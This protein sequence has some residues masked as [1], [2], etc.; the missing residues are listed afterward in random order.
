MDLD[1]LRVI[2][3]RDRE[4]A[5][6]VIAESANQ[7]GFGVT[8]QDEPDG[9][10]EIDNIVLSGMG[11]SCLA[12]LMAKSWLDH[13]YQLSIPFEITRGYKLPSYVN[14]KTL[15]ICLSVSGNTEETLSSFDDAI[16]RGAKVVA[17][18]SGGKLLDLAREKKIPFTQL[19]KISQPRYGIFMHLRV[20]ARILE[21][22][23]LIQGAYRE[24]E[25]AAPVVKRYADKLTSAIP[26]SRNQAKLLATACAG[27]TPLVYASSLFYPLAYK[28]KTSFNENAKNTI[29]C[30]EFSEF[31]HNEFI[32]WT[33]HPID[34][35]F[36]IINLR[37]NIDSDRMNQRFD[38]TDQLL[39]GHRPAAHNISLYGNSVLEQMICGAILGDFASIYL[40]IINGVDPTPVPLVEKFKH[41]LDS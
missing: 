33:S 4:N 18:S 34:K 7:L 24:I 21:S 17:V 20:I 36:A 10:G 16:N 41:L 35:P 30:N 40:G 8:I 27:K 1:N 19:D 29:W 26:F 38:L 23:G 31:N 22:A 11:G 6:G 39:S 15:V 32:G 37:S 3:E 2:K 12:G 14:D 9:W 5:L 13:D 25:S 28:W